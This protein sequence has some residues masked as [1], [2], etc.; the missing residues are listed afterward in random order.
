VIALVRAAVGGDERAF[1]SLY[2]AT[3]GRVYAICLRMTGDRDRATELTQDVFVKAWER[4]DG[5]RGESAFESWLHRI[6]VNVVL[7][8]ERSTRRRIARVEPTDDLAET[9]SAQML[10]RTEAHDLDRM[11]LEAAIAAL[12][13]A[14]RRVFILH[15]I[16]GYKHEEISRMTGSAQGTLRA[17][18][19]RA[20]RLLM[21]ALTR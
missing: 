8:S 6:A 15:D 10:R 9:E 17:Q 13:P 20:R 12:P 11:D 1:E 7:E 18:L 3:V 2:R 19:F 4:M 16:E 21:E 14:T 5:F